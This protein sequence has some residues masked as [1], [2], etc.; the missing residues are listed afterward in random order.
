MTDEQFWRSTLRQINILGGRYIKE[1]D[2]AE[3]GNAGDL[4][5]WAMGRKG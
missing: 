5:S 3:Q 4:R 2:T 1:E